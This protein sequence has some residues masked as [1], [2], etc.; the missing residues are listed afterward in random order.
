MRNFIHNKDDV[1]DSK[2]SSQT[3]EMHEIKM[4]TSSEHKWWLFSL[5]NKLGSITFA[6]RQKIMNDI[7]RIGDASIAA[8]ANHV[9]FRK[10]N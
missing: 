3:N 2:F 5:V 6:Y 4:M 1:D 8:E 10:P 7:G 9:M